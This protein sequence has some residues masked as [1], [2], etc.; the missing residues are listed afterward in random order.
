[1]AQR[2]RLLPRRVDGAAVAAGGPRGASLGRAADDPP[3]RRAHVQPALVGRRRRRV[4]SSTLSARL[5]RA[6]RA[7]R[8]HESEQPG[9]HLV[10]DVVRRVESPRSDRE[11]APDRRVAARAGAIVRSPSSRRARYRAI[12]GTSAPSRLLAQGFQPRERL[13]RMA[14]GRRVR[15]ALWALLLAFGV[16]LWLA[17]LLLFA[18]VAEDSDD[19][20][21]LQNWILLVNSLGVALLVT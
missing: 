2:R 11:P 15:R 10:P 17:A 16:V 14:I 8:R 9:S 5:S 7:L 21:R 6:D 20:A 19:F 3:R 18:R 13:V 12:S 4:A 1:Q